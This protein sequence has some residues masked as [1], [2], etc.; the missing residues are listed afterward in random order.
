MGETKDD[1]WSVG[2][3]YDQ[4]FWQAPDNDKKNLRFFTGC[5]LSDG[6]PS[7]GRWGGFASVESWGLLPGREKDRMGVG[8]FY[9][10]LSSEFK[11]LTS[12]IGVDLSNVWGTE[13]YYNA[14]ITPWFHLTG[15]VQV[16]QNQNADNDPG[17][18]LGLRA[19]LDF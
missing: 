11:E 9:N 6:N 18:I 3:Y 4:I 17:V 14:E 7:F 1:A 8:A 13:V 5:S 2:A 16:V 15:D 10:Q 19:V 12:A